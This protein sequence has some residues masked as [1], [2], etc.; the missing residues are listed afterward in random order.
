MSEV[1]MF[2]QDDQDRESVYLRVSKIEEI[3]KEICLD[4]TH[5]K[6]ERMAELKKIN[7]EYY[8]LTYLLD[9]DIASDEWRSAT[10]D[11]LFANE[12][13]IEKSLK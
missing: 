9:Q 2:I 5:S 4:Q 12:V 7:K 13:E 10:G 8:K 3:A 6:L 1:N 11:Y